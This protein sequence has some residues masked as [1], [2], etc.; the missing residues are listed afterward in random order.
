MHLL[1][2]IFTYLNLPYPMDSWSVLRFS[3]Y[4]P[5]YVLKTHAAKLSNMTL[6]VPQWIFKPAERSSKIHVAPQ[7][8]YHSFASFTSSRVRD[9]VFMNLMKGNSAKK[10]TKCD[11]FDQNITSSFHCSAAIIIVTTIAGSTSW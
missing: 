9:E 1:Y 6:Q 8:Y 11:I 4:S 2:A 3:T 5:T 10:A 7:R